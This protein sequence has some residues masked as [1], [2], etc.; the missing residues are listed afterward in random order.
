MSSS[1]PWALDSRVPLPGE[2]HLVFSNIS[3]FPLKPALLIVLLLGN[4]DFFLTLVPSRSHP[5]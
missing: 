1:P 2:L 3:Q 5:H 4:K